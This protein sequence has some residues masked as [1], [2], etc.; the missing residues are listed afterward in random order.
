VSTEPLFLDLDAA[1]ENEPAKIFKVGGHTFQCRTFVRPEALTAY[2]NLSMN[3]SAEH[4]RETLDGVV[5]AFLPP[6]QHD[7]WRQ[8]R[9]SDEIGLRGREI[10]QIVKHLITVEAGQQDAAH[11]TSGP[12]ASTDGPDPS[13]GSSAAGSSSPEAPPTA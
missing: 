3:D 8:V 9:A 2:E 10:N 11:P 5:L 4:W 1:R 6:E 13:D 7:L 12:S